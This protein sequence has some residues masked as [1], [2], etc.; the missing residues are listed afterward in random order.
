[1]QVAFARLCLP[2][3]RAAAVTAHGSGHER[4]VA[5]AIDELKRGKIVFIIADPGFDVQGLAECMGQ[6][7]LNCK[8]AICEDLGY[9]SERIEI[10]TTESPPEAR[11]RLFS[12]VAWRRERSCSSRGS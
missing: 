10:G 8:I 12:I 3:A 6:R 11:S 1:M 4:A 2:L 7:G 9:G 5:E